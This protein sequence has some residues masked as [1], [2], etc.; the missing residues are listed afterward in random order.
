MPD[1]PSGRSGGHPALTSP[2][3]PPGLYEGFEGLQAEECGILNG[4]ENGRCVRVPEGYTCDCFDGFQL[5]MTRMACVG[6]WLPVLLQL[7]RPRHPLSAAALCWCWLGRLL[8]ASPL[9]RVLRGLGAGKVT[10]AWQPASALPTS[11]HLGASGNRGSSCS[12]PSSG[13]TPVPRQLLLYFCL[14]S[15]K[16]TLS[17]EP[18]SLK[19]LSSSLHPHS[20]S[21]SFPQRSSPGQPEAPNRP[22]EI[23]LF[24]WAGHLL[25][26]PP[27]LLHNTV[28]QLH[29]EPVASASPQGRAAA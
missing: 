21:P 19:L 5:D 13:N 6:E 9:Q 10:P 18:R 15:S 16:S 20:V 2:C 8:E 28:V 17:Y 25:Q 27:P 12:Q 24:P 22:E 1:V 29:T 7:G 14:L 3:H 26:L 23:P 4:C 11:G